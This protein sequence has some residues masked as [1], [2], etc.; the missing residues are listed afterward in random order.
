[1][2]ERRC[3]HCKEEESAHH[4]FEPEWK[5]P[6]G[7]LCDPSEWLVPPRAIC[8]AFNGR[9]GDGTCFNCEH[10]EECHRVVGGPDE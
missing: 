3:L 10:I 5:L 4:A 8:E 1:M 9:S 7:C 6:E 2:T